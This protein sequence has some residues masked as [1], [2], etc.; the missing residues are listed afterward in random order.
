MRSDINDDEILKRLTNWFTVNPA[1]KILLS[2]SKLLAKVWSRK[3]KWNIPI[4]RDIY[5]WW[6][7]NCVLE[8]GDYY[9]MI[10]R[11]ENGKWK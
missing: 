9:L 11:L 2:S 7:D 10:D 3:G 8:D 4:H 1:G 5:V 6:D